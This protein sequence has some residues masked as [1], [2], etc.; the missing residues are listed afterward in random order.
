MQCLAKSAYAALPSLLPTRFWMGRYILYLCS[1]GS[2]IDAEELS[3]ILKILQGTRQPAL[4]MRYTQS[5]CETASKDM[6]G[7]I[8]LCQPPDAEIGYAE[9]IKRAEAGFSKLFSEHPFFP[10]FQTPE[11]DSE[12]IDLGS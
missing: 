9:A 10:A 2:P 8:S 3:N 11:E 7:N 5:C 4:T 6:P 1:R 12:D